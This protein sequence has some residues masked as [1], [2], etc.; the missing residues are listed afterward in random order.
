VGGIAG[1]AIG[2]ALGG[3][4][5][6]AV[7]T[8]L[9]EMAGGAL[10]KYIGPYWDGMSEKAGEMMSNAKN[11]VVN[12]MS[13]LG[14]ASWDAGTSFVGALISG[15]KK[16]IELLGKVGSY[17][18][19]GIKNTPIFRFGKVMLD[20]M[21]AIP[22]VASFVGVAKSVASAIGDT[23]SGV[24]DW[25]KGKMSNILPDWAKRFLNESSDKAEGRTPPPPP[26]PKPAQPTVAKPTS[27]QPT[28]NAPQKASTDAGKQGPAN[29]PAAKPA[30]TSKSVAGKTPDVTKSGTVTEKDVPRILNDNL[31]IM[32]HVAKQNAQMINYL[33]AMADNSRRTADA[34]A[35]MSR[36]G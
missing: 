20:S 17:I 25:I 10:G 7:G 13:A 12:G 16:V 36:Q 6:A 3:P 4:I 8:Y 9:G 2:F 19:E 14:K 15:G 22:W 34:T 35:K 11:A 33:A 5:G 1:G 31:K 32:D 18:W 23:I 21:L 24:F 30:D 29:Q 27:P 26:P 28:T